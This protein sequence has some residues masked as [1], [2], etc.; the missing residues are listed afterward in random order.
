MKVRA[1]SRP[2]LGRGSDFDHAAVGGEQGAA[3]GLAGVYG[4]QGLAV[5]GQLGVVGGLFFGAQGAFVVQHPPFVAACG[6]AAADEA[7]DAQLLAFV[8]QAGFVEG[9]DDVL[10]LPG[11]G[12]LAG[13]DGL[14]EAGGVGGLLGAEGVLPLR[15]LQALGL[16]EVEGGVC[17]PMAAGAFEQPVHGLADAGGGVVGGGWRFGRFGGF[18]GFGR[19]RRGDELRQGG[20]LGCGQG[21]RRQGGLG[22]PVGQGA[23]VKGQGA[24]GFARLGRLAGCGF[25]F[26]FN[27]PGDGLQ[28]LPPGGAFGAGGAAGEHQALLRAGDGHVKGVEFFAALF[29]FFLFEQFARAGRGVAFAEQRDRK[30]VV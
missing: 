13:V 3:Y 19:R 11:P 20:G 24:G 22:L 9:F 29:G 5:A 16:G 26:G 6:Q 21:G 18:E 23:D 25:E 8:Q 4:L 30:S 28:A 15:A 10:F 12:G 2:G 17:V 14:G 7:V 1:G 27:G